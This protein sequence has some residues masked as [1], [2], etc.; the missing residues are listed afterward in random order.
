M[1]QRTQK[2][3]M[4]ALPIHRK[5]IHINPRHAHAF[6]HRDHEIIA[7]WRCIGWDLDID[8]LP[9]TAGSVH[10]K[11]TQ[12]GVETLC[13]YFALPHL[14]RLQ[15]WVRATLAMF[16]NKTSASSP[17]LAPPPPSPCCA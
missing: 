6:V 13:F 3:E 15:R 9:P 1:Q 7:L 14:V 8:M 12:T 11:L 10:Y 4:L 16:R 2:K 17:P 5:G